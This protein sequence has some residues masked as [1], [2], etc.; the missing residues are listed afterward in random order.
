MDVEEIWTHV[1]AERQ[2]LA[3]LM[4]A[5]TP[6]QWNTPSLC[7]GW[8]VR[9]VAAHVT[10]STRVRPLAAMRGLVRAKGNFNAYVAADAKSRAGELPALFVEQLRAATTSRS[11]PPGTR[12]VDPL[13]DV[14]VHGQ[15]IAVPLGIER[16]MPTAAA[17]AAA[18]RVWAMGFPFR[19]KK[20]LAGVAVRATN[21]SWG[22][23]EG[24]ELAGPIEAI[25]LV[26]TGRKAGLS[27]LQGK[28]RHLIEGSLT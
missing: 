22:E 1:A 3:E 23:G 11:H 7:E 5:L 28:G 19:A 10:L 4:E 9:D 27:S 24:P 21:A 17:M 26:L 6:E 20:R 15:D 8:R 14:L 13:V 16:R 12:P 18:D 2:S 25:L